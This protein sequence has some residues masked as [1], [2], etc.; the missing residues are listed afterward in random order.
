MHCGRNIISTT[1]WLLSLS[2][3]SPVL[4]FTGLPLPLLSMSLITYQNVIVEK[5]PK[6]V[7]LVYVPKLLLSTYLRFLPLDMSF[8][9]RH[10]STY[11]L[12]WYPCRV[13]LQLDCLW[14]HL[15][16]KVLQLLWPRPCPASQGIQCVPEL[17]ATTVSHSPMGVEWVTGS[18]YLS[19]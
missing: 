17:T 7:S 6:S 12:P 16:A 3:G 13:V 18:S 19:H 4:C 2:A 1:L 10:S 11:P 15:S 8:C 9:I 5:A 14:N